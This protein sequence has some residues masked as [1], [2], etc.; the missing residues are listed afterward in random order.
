MAPVE[1]ALAQLAPEQV[2]GFDEQFT[3]T[4]NRFCSLVEDSEVDTS[5]SSEGEEELFSDHLVPLTVVTRSQ[6]KKLKVNNHKKKNK[7]KSSG[8]KNR[9]R[10]KGTSKKT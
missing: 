9:G 2:D 4:P 7:K 3:V 10:P 5:V 6:A 8:K 1:Q